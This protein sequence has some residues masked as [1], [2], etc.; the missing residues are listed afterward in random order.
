M[1]V[2][3]GIAAFIILGL[4]HG[5]LLALMAPA[6]WDSLMGNSPFPSPPPA[7][8]SVAADAGLE[9]RG[10][11]V[12]GGE[13]LFCIYDPSTRLSRWVGANEPGNPFTVQSYDADQAT[14]AVQYGGRVLS[15]ALKQARVVLLVQNPPPAQ[16]AP[17]PPPAASAGASGVEETSRQAAAVE[18]I[19]RRRTLRIQATR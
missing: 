7:A 1:T 12:D 11:L 13:H 17:I 9:F 2:R 14:V 3:R 5:R 15:L 19:R 8:A 10:V 16:P 6:K 4:A 18:E